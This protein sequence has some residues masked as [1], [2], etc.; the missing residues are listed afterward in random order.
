MMAGVYRSQA[1][2]LASI[3]VLL[4]G[5]LVTCHQAFYSVSTQGPATT[6]GEDRRFAFAWMIAEPRTDDPD[7]FLTKRGAPLLP[8]LSFAAYVSSFPQNY[9]LALQPDQF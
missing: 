9:V 4:C 5:A 1:E 7:R 8:S 6:A 2:A 3:T